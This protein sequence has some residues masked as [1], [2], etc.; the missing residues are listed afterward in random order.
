MVPLE[1][2]DGTDIICCREHGV[3]HA[4]NGKIQRTSLT[5]VAYAVCEYMERTHAN[6]WNTHEHTRDCK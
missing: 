1:G 6:I 3:R 5:D 4:E 2:H